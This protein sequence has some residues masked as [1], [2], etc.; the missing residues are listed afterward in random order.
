[1]PSYL[2][3]D[4]RA[5]D[6][7]WLEGA[8]SVGITAGASAPDELVQ[9]L[10]AKLRERGEVELVKLPGVTENVRFRMPNELADAAQ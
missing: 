9:D 1:V 8:E 2:I 7:K 5:L 3:E 4:A 10:I 6:M